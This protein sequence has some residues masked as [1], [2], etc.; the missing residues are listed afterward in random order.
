ML[1]RDQKHIIRELNSY[2]Y[3]LFKLDD[4][5]ESFARSLNYLDNKIY[6][7]DK[8]LSDC[9]V[10]A[11]QYDKVPTKKFKRNSRIV[12]LIY[13]QENLKKR[14]DEIKFEQNKSVDKIVQ[15]IEDIEIYLRKLN[16]WERQF[17]TSMYI[18]SRCLDYM[19]DTYNYSR[20]TVF[21]KATTI[22]NKMLEK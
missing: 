10:K 11:V 6:E 19:T 3:L 17:I 20:T 7:I 22:L 1:T 16:N 13:E 12:E 5:T 9:G 21:R 15:R 4:M 18:E 8:E 2:N 14:K